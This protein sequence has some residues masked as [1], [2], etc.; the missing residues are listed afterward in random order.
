MWVILSSLC[1][2]SVFVQ[3]LC[4]SCKHSRSARSVSIENNECNV[5]PNCYVAAG[6]L[7]IGIVLI[8]RGRGPIRQ[9]SRGRQVSRRT[10]LLSHC[11]QF[12]QRWS[13]R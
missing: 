4:L 11:L 3:N 10:P 7:V 9:P 2:G 5:C 8:R 1:G 6:L 13:V 12:L